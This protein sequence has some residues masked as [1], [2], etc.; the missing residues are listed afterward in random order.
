MKIF[1]PD[2]TDILLQNLARDGFKSAEYRQYSL[3]KEK[4]WDRVFATNAIYNPKL[5]YYILMQWKRQDLMIFASAAF[6]N[7][8]TITVPNSIYG[9]IDFVCIGKNVDGEGHYTFISKEV[10]CFRCFDAKE[11]DN[12][13]SARASYGN[14]R[15]SQSNIL[16]WLNSDA[17]G[18]SWFCA[19]DEDEEIDAPPNSDNTDCNAY[20]SDLGFLCGFDRDFIN[21]LQNVTRVTAKSTT[22]GG[23]TENVSSFVTD[24]GTGYQKFFLLSASEINLAPAGLPSEGSAYPYF[25]ATTLN[26]R[27][28]PSD[29][30][31]KQCNEIWNSQSAPIYPFINRPRKHEPCAWWLRTPYPYESLDPTHVRVRK[32]EN[33]LGAVQASAGLIGVRPAFVF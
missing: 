13:V 21:K 20:E 11:P 15:Y 26:G 18:G 17:P 9:D 19:Q 25:T 29:Y 12:T 31:I 2:E 6:G 10:V 32:A 23:G 3:Y 4:L 22:D 30:A 8:T 7:G 16:Q 5:L 27:A 28:Y 1:I 14:N 24:S 33:E